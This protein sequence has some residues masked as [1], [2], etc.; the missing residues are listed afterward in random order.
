MAEVIDVVER[1]ARAIY[2][3][4]GG[5]SGDYDDAAFTGSAQGGSMTTR[6]EISDWFDRGVQHPRSQSFGGVSPSLWTGSGR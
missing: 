4:L 5:G 3:Q 2:R 1:V 6:Q